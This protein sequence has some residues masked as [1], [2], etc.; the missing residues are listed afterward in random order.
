MHI[1]GFGFRWR[2]LLSGPI[3]ACRSADAQAG[4]RESQMV[5]GYGCTGRD[6]FVQKNSQSHLHPV[7]HLVI[8]LVALADKKGGKVPDRSDEAGRN[9]YESR[10]TQ[11]GMR[12]SE[13]T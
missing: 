1:R 12:G 5:C 8:Y 9:P 10:C 3:P 4:G 2:I 11:G 6:A 7:W 13:E